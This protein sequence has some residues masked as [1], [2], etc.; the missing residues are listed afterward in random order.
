MLDGKVSKKDKWYDDV[1]C[2][3]N[4]IVCFWDVVVVA[5]VT[6]YIHYEHQYIQYSLIVIVFVNT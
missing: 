2:I 6:I 1:S 4:D 5:I 3:T